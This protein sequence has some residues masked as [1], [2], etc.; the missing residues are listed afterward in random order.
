MAK[1]LAT[2]LDNPSTLLEEESNRP[3][4]REVFTSLPCEGNR[5]NFH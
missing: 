1:S 4:K 5:R 2:S 3:Y